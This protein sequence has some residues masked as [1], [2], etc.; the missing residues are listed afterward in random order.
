MSKGGS[1]CSPEL[2]VLFPYFK[3]KI[4][5]RHAEKKT[6]M[7]FSRTGVWLKGLCQQHLYGYKGWP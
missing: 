6:I 5:S 2:L 1:S 7:K 3:A 4:K